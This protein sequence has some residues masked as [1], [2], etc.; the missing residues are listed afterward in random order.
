[1]KAKLHNFTFENNF[2]LSK[3]D[4]TILFYT[5][6]SIARGLLKRFQC[7]GCQVMVSSSRETI[8]LKLSQKNDNISHWYSFIPLLGGGGGGTIYHTGK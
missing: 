6:G 1:M 8:R 2:L 3:A 5:A 7:V 4:N